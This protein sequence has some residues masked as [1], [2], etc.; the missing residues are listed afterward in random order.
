MVAK[1]KPALET[2]MDECWR[3]CYQDGKDNCAQCR[4]FNEK[5]AGM[6][7]CE[8]DFRTRMVG[9]GCEKCNPEKAMDVAEDT[10]AELQDKVAALEADIKDA[11]QYVTCTD[12]R[13]G[14][15]AGR[16][17][18]TASYDRMRGRG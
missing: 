4:A 14:C 9:D 8:C 2:T 13:S 17:M 6:S 10:I 15:L 16:V 7:E 12:G 3:T 11:M 1:I 5:G 18:S